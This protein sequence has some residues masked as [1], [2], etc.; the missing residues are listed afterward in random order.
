[1]RE[2][3]FALEEHLIFKGM[4]TDIGPLFSSWLSLVGEPKYGVQVTGRTMGR[5]YVSARIPVTCRPAIAEFI[6]DVESGIVAW[7]MWHGD[8]QPMPPMPGAPAVFAP[9]A[10]D[11]GG[12]PWP[13]G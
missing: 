12:D 7:P 2:V 1:M 10:V 11:R 5:H 13:T 8:V 3:T 4:G 6:S 9:P